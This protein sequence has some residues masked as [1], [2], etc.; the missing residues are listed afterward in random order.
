MAKSNK[1]KHGRVVQLASEPPALAGDYLRAFTAALSKFNDFDA[2][3]ERLKLVVSEDAY[4]DG[5][6]VLTESSLLKAEL[7]DFENLSAGA[8]V[9]AVSGAAGNMGYLKYAGRKDTQLFGAEDLHLLGSIAGFVGALIQQAQE[10]RRKTKVEQVLHYLMNRLPLGVVCMNGGN[11]LMVQS[12]QAERLLG[13]EGVTRLTNA[14][15]FNEDAK[16]KVQFHLVVDGRLLFAEGRQFT[17]ASGEY[18]K[19]FVIYDLSKSRETLM[20]HLEREAYRS[21][22][23][24]TPVT[25][26]LLESNEVAGAIYSK[27]KEAASQMLLSP[28]QVQ[29]L[30]A[31]RCALVFTGKPLVLVRYLLRQMRFIRESKGLNAAVVAYD[32]GVLSD[33]PAETWVARAIAKL[34]PAASSLLPRFIAMDRYP[35]VVD[36]LALTLADRCELEECLN[37]DESIR[38]IESG[39]FDGMFYDLDASSPQQLLQ[40]KRAAAVCGAEFKFYFCT[41]R[42]RSMVDPNF[43]IMETEVVLQK[44]F[45]AGEVSEVFA[46]DFE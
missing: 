24:G 6:A 20:M 19:V 35:S 33:M 22:S 37:L 7:P 43:A 44:P 34:R 18:L 32:Q 1:V 26:A 36:S 25:I 9:V 45:L 38:R 21:E 39:D 8:T 11:E 12:Q 40:L 31:N 15:E 29:P 16:L 41:C 2:F 30:D 23:R 42:R 10:S 27:A 3:L 4:L 46:L 28:D 5:R 17:I 13:D 14:A